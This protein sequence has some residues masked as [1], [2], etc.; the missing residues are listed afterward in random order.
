MGNGLSGRLV[1]GLLLCVFVCAFLTSCGGKKEQSL[2]IKGRRMYLQDNRH[3]F[4]EEVFVTKDK[5]KVIT[6]LPGFLTG[7]GPIK[8]IKL[9]RKDTNKTLYFFPDKKMYCTAPSE[10][11]FSEWVTSYLRENVNVLPQAETKKSIAGHECTFYGPGR[12]GS[13]SSAYVAPDLQGPA[14][15]ANIV[16]VQMSEL[17]GSFR[18]SL[19]SYNC[20]PLKV[21][22]VFRMTSLF[23]FT[24]SE[25]RIGPI[26]ESVFEMPADYTES[27]YRE[28]LDTF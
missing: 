14:I 22:G 1:C 19:K 18:Q 17:P 2:Y 5:I 4:T 9:F 27:T 23:S 7:K 3:R 6:E 11:E 13:G 24:A 20:V 21:E 16:N 10:S 12:T 28:I 25:V 8:V 26:E 15:V